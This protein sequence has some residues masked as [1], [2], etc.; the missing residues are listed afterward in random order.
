L[1][2]LGFLVVFRVLGVSDFWG[3]TRA[4]FGGAG[5]Q[6]PWG[7]PRRRASPGGGSWF[8]RGP[9]CRRGERGGRGEKRQHRVSRGAE[10]V[11][12]WAAADRTPVARRVPVGRAAAFPGCRAGL[13]DLLHRGQG[14]TGGSKRPWGRGAIQGVLAGYGP[15]VG[16]LSL[17]GGFCAGCTGGAAV[18]GV[19][20]RRGSRG[21]FFRESLGAVEVR[22]ST[23]HGRPGN[24]QVRTGC[25]QSRAGRLVEGV[26]AV[27]S[28]VRVAD[29]LGGGGVSQ[30]RSRCFVRGFWRRGLFHA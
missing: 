13:A 17:L 18:R 22:A 24:F 23:R 26:R 30:G 10:W 4:W 19:E 16:A 9:G 2:T 15:V 5:A 8:C 20:G 14:W 7:R 11:W 21:T 12:L 6:G 27:S 1:K 3:R 28:S 29:G 25:Y